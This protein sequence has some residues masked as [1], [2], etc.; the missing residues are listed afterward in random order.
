VGFRYT[1]GRLPDS[2]RPRSWPIGTAAGTECSLTQ[3]VRYGLFALKRRRY[4]PA[5]VGGSARCMDAP[6]GLQRETPMIGRT[7][8]AVRAKGRLPVFR[9]RAAALV[10]V[11]YHPAQALPAGDG[12]LRR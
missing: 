2:G 6:L 8:T 3:T 9:L 11:R 10:P 4:T 1:A 12:R 5:T 7:A